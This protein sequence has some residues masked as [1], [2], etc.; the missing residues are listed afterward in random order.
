MSQVGYRAVPNGLCYFDCWHVQ[1]LRKGLSQSDVA[2]PC[3][4]VKV[5][6]LIS[7]A[8]VI[9]SSGLIFYNGGG[10]HRV[11]PVLQ[12]GVQCR[13]INKR[14]ENTAG[15]PFGNGVV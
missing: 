1:R 12:A 10:R 8:A 5:Y 2:Q 4:L 9:E 7:F 3:S 14:L 6:W 13:G 15:R 11:R